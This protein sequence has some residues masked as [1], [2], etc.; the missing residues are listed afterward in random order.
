MSNI[1]A[2]I[3]EDEARN[4][5]VLKSLLGRY[6]P[7]VDIHSVATTVK[8]A[9]DT[10]YEVD[11]DLVFLDIELPDASGFK[12][13]EHFP[14]KKFNVIF[15]TAFE[16]YAVKAIKASALDYLLKPVD[17][18]D[19][20]AAVNKAEKEINNP[21][22][23]KRKEAFLYNARQDSAVKQKIALPTIDGLLFVN[24]EDIIQ[25]QA[26]GNY[27]YFYLTNKD[28]IMV[29]KSLNYFED[30]LDEELFCRTHQSHLVNLGHIKKYIK[31]RGGYILMSDDSKVEVS[32]RMKNDFLDR[33][34][35]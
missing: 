17:I 3:V 25:C 24:Q 12:V 26:E 32:V 27:T 29:S 15:V 10:I 6:C 16:H 4:A 20:V 28:K 33:F 13:I 21:D 5:D 18:D 30:V 34:I 8:Q 11:P 14:Q 19:L 7:N 31:G 23:A 9:I 2:I 1:K 35:K 22:V